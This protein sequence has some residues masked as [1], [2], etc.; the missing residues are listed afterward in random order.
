MPLTLRA[1]PPTDTSKITPFPTPAP[2]AVPSPRELHAGV[3]SM[4]AKQRVPLLALPSSTALGGPLPLTPRASSKITLCST[5]APSAVLSR[6]LHAGVDSMPAKKRVP[7][8]ALPSSSAQGGPLPLTPRGSSSTDTSKITSCSTLAPPHH[9]DV[10]SKRIRKSN[11]VPVPLALPST[12]PGGPLAT[13]FPRAPVNAPVSGVCVL[14][15]ATLY[16][17]TIGYALQIL[18][19][20]PPVILAFP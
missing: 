9:A 13:H 16:I 19:I 11:R 15:P 4:P 5:L 14:H 20:T 2:L 3:D 7:L 6:G 1:S 12:A 8:L 17:V 18:L 10:G